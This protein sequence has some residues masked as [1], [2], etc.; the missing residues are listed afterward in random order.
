V[1][2]VKATHDGTNLYIAWQV[3]DPLS[4][5]KN[6]AQDWKTLFKQGDC[7]DLMIGP[8]TPEARPQ[9]VQGDVRLLLAPAETDSIAVLYQPVAAGAPVEARTP[10]ESPVHQFTMDSVT[11]MDKAVVKFKPIEGGYCVELKLPFETLGVRY[12]AGLHLLGD[13]GVLSSNEG[14]QLTERRCY[15]FNH[16]TNV[17]SDL[18]TEAELSPMNWGV[19]VLE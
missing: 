1:G 11:R 6:A 4:P 13:F 10:F 3:I 18:P 7:V 9:A 15:L 5:M 2:T 8:V 19:I 12:S 16:L 14:G 17:V